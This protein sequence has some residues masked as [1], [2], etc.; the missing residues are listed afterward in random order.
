MIWWVTFQMTWVREQLLLQDNHWT[1][2]FPPSYGDLHQLVNLSLIQSS[3]S[4]YRGLCSSLPITWETL[5][6]LEHVSFC[7][8]SHLPDYIGVSWQELCEFTIIG[9]EYVSNISLSLYNLNK[10]DFSYCQFTG[11]IFSMP[12]LQYLDLSHNGLS[13]PI[14]EIIE[15]TQSIEHLVLAYNYLNSTLPWNISKLN[16]LVFLSLVGS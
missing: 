16:N 12:S 3:P 11:I 6:S 7:T 8:F 13:G 5:F 2:N 15:T 9:G 14:L 1:R 10:L 4:Q